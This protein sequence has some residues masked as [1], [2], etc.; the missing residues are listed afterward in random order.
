M[1]KVKIL[2]QKTDF[3]FF[4]LYEYKH[5]IAYSHNIPVLILGHF[6]AVY[7]MILQDPF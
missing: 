7:I 6:I 5:F 1:D 2:I 3:F 4:T